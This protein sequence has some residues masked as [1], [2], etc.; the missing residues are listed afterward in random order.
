MDDGIA[1]VVFDRGLIEFHIRSVNPEAAASASSL[2]A[3]K[4]HA[5]GDLLVSCRS[6]I[7]VGVS[8]PI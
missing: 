6:V 5:L 8:A 7:G 2:I 1:D 4:S 3:G